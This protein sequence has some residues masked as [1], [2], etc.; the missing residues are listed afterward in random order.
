MTQAIVDIGKMPRGGRILNIGSIA[1]KM[2]MAAMATY[3]AAKAAQD[4]LTASWA[5][6]VSS[7]TLCLVYVKFA[8]ALAQLG[9]KRGITVNTLA[10]GPIMTDAAKPFLTSPDGAPSDMQSS[11]IA[12]T[13]AEERIGRTEDVADAA[14]LMVSE[15]SRWI[16]AQFISVSGGV[17]GTM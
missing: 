9:V 1:S 3:S 12:M 10:P 16:T 6:E 13:R 5:S 2:G 15:K 7:P 8:D 4:S 14:L 17:L 11:M